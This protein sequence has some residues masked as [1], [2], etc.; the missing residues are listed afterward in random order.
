MFWSFISNIAPQ[1]DGNRLKIVSWNVKGLH[2]PNKRMSILR[3]LKRLRTDVTLLQETHPSADN[4]THKLWV[5][6]VY[7]SPE[8][9][10]KAG[11]VILLHRNLRHAVRNVRTDSTGCKMRIHMTLGAKDI[12][13]TNVSLFFKTWYPGY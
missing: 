8:V 3:H 7:G 5:G 9:G 4:L 2:T 11:M 13:I 6:E 12:A 10:C 1:T